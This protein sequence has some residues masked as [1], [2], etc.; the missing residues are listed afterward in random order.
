MRHIAPFPLTLALKLQRWREGGLAK[1]IKF[2]FMQKMFYEATAVIF[3]RAEFLRENLTPAEKILW[4]FLRTKP[5]G[6][7]FRRQH[8][9][10]RFITDFYCHP[11]K[12]VIEVDGSLHDNREVQQ[13]DRAKQW[14]LEQEGIFVLRLKNE[15]VINDFHEATAIIM[16]T[17][18]R[19]SQITPP[20]GGRG[21]KTD[22]QF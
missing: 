18:A 5:C 13:A 20:L 19:R 3:K 21:A 7:K 4:E 2:S 8:P 14:S 17:I 22:C 15:V 12:I 9:I 6:Y 1:M 10:G 16:A 11:L